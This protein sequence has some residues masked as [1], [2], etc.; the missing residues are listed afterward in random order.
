MHLYLPGDVCP[1]SVVSGWSLISFKP[2]RAADQRVDK[3]RLENEI[4]LQY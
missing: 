1:E 3:V 2:H 4:K